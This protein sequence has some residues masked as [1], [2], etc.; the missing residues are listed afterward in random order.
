MVN[1][2]RWVMYFNVL[3]KVHDQ[4]GDQL[5]LVPNNVSYSYGWTD[6]RGVY[7]HQHIKKVKEVHYLKV[8]KRLC[9]PITD[10]VAN[11]MRSV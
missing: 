11:I 1:S 6:A 4:H 3:Y 8:E 5:F 10:E 2:P 7:G 9:Q